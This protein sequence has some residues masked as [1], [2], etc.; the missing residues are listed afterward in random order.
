MK[1]WKSF[2]KDDYSIFIDLFYSQLS[3]SIYDLDKNLKSTIYDPICYYTIPIPKNKDNINIYDCL[4]L[5]TDFEKMDEENKWYNEETKEYIECYKQIK[6]WNTPKILIIVF[7]RFLKNG[8]KNT[9]KID[10]PINELNLNK[11]FINYKKNKNIYDL[12]GISNHIGNLN[13][14]HYYAYCKNSLNNKWYNY[15]DNNV[16]EIKEEDLITDSAYCLFYEKDKNKV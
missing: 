3:S 1:S 12:I 11:Y 16:S 10:F 8:Q 14:G 15:N 13:F 2:F 9:E 4:D 7:K 6:F 5:Y